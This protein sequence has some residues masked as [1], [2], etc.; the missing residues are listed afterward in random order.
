MNKKNSGT[1]LKK[2]NFFSVRKAGYSELKKK[3]KVERE[4]NTERKKE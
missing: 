2:S 4:R 3:K 1:Y